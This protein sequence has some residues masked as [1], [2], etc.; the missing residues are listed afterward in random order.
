MKKIAIIFG[1]RPEAIKLA[2]LIK[3]FK[4]NSSE[5][6]IINISTGQHKEMLDQVVNFFNLSINYDLSLMT[7]NQSLSELSSK[8]LIS[9]DEVLKKE[10]PDYVF[11]H[12]DTT[13]TAFASISA[14]YNKIKLCHIEAGLRTFDKF[15]PFP[16]EINRTITGKL[17]DLH[18]APT[19]QAMKNLINEGIK[20]DSICVTGNTVVD[21]LLDAVSISKT[22]DDPQIESLKKIV[23]MNKK[24]ILVTGHRRENFGKGFQNICNA[25]QILSKNPK[26]HIVYPVHLNP[27]VKNVVFENLKDKKNISLIN[28]LGYPAFTWLMDKSYLILTDSGGVQEEAPS[29]GIPVLVMRNNT[30]RP[31]GIK[32]K[33]AF[34]V[35]TNTEKIIKNVYQF[36]DDKNWYNKVSKNTNPYGDGNASKKIIQFLKKNG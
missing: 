27:N 14:F 7:P 11:V 19:E 25:L 28:P 23:P 17:T 4:K 16:E 36:L 13:T 12:G 1:T 34:I 18:F 15:S 24:I 21:A 9:L 31:E 6:E 33:T 26:I 35:G 29:L 8:I 5:F 2:P 10:K 20:K 32:A 22:S 30:E 3:E